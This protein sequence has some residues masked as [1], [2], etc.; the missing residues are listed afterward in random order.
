[1]KK[2]VMIL[3]ASFLMAASVE[4]ERP[5]DQ[6][7]DKKRKDRPVE[8]K[9]PPVLMEKRVAPK[10]LT[11]VIPYAQV[12]D[13]IKAEDVK[14][15][16]KRVIGDKQVKRQLARELAQLS[17]LSAQGEQK[18]EIEGVRL[19]EFDFENKLITVRLE[20]GECRY[21]IPRNPHPVYSYPLPR[22]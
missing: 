11:P 1:M 12:E 19:G 9:R 15:A 13:C 21:R 16:L 10:P 2:T 7:L 14:A 17:N 20:E 6:Q 4:A 3:A 8:L 22:R 18:T 5:S